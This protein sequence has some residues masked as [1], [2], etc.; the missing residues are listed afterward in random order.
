MRFSKLLIGMMLALTACTSSEPVANT[1]IVLSP[2]STVV[3]SPIATAAIAASVTPMSRAS[4][5]PL[6]LQVVMPTLLPSA[7]LAATDTPT[8]V[9]LPTVDATSTQAEEVVGTY[10][11]SRPIEQV[12]GDDRVDYID[13]TYPYGGTQFGAREIHLGVEF[14][15]QRFTPVVAAADGEVVFAGIDSEQQIGPRLDYYGNVTILK[16]QFPNVETPVYTLY[17]HLQDIAVEVGQQIERGDRVGRVGD[18]GI[19]IGPHLHF[20]VRQ[21]DD[22]FDYRATRNPALWIAPY[23]GFGTLAGLVVEAHSEV[24]EPET[25]TV[26]VR[27]AMGNWETYVYG[28]DRVNVSDEL[29]ENFVVPDLPEGDYEVIVSNR[30]GRLLFRQDMVIEAG[31]TTWIE[32]DLRENS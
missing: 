23:P 7:T 16:H 5:T 17:A 28:S 25:R 14:V 12:N 32:I 24:A 27:S 21:G 30:N 31:Q 22:A 13:R 15:N 19:A 9:S 29:G 26:L 2:T 6:Q 20:E 8:L 4:A 1:A 18:T 3:V 10:W 11:L